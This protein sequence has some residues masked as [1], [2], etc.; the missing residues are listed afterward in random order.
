MQRKYN[1]YSL[2]LSQKELREMESN[3]YGLMVKKLLIHI[4]AQELMFEERVRDKS[5]RM[6]SA[7]VYAKLERL[8]EL[9]LSLEKKIGGGN[10]NEGKV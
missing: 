10:S 3:N 2:L 5:T 4:R 7:A 6:N 9:I 8:E 1:C